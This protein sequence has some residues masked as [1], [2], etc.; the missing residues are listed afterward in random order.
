MLVGL[1]PWKPEGEICVPDEPDGIE[2]CEY[3][4]DSERGFVG[5][6]V[7]DRWLSHCGDVGGN[8]DGLSCG[9]RCSSQ[10]IIK[11]DGR[12]KPGEKR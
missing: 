1:A 6:D 2:A 5:V 4:C 10:C 11:L 12:T 8:E 7:V 9:S 3:G